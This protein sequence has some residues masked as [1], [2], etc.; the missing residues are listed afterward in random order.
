MHHGVDTVKM[1]PDWESL[2]NSVG[3]VHVKK[4]DCDKNSEAASAHGVQDFLQLCI[5]KME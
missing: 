2:G 5:S 1:M 4:V 3:N